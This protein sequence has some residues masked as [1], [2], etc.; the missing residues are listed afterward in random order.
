[1]LTSNETFFIPADAYDTV[2]GP[3]PVAVAGVAPA[4]KFQS[5][6]VAPVEASVKVI[7]CP[8]QAG[9]GVALKPAIADE[10][11]PVKLILSK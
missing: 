8:T 11:T 7:F 1:M 3:T 6:E 9:S 5:Q 10:V 4:P 2:C